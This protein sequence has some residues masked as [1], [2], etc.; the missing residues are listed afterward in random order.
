MGLRACG[1]GGC[2]FYSG[3]WGSELRRCF[4]VRDAINAQTD[5]YGVANP[6]VEIPDMERPLKGVTAVGGFN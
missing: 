4:F 2:S 3:R 1:W 6:Y 5:K